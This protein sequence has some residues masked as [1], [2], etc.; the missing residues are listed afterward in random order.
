MLTTFGDII[1]ELRGYGLYEDIFMATCVKYIGITYR[2]GLGLVVDV[3]TDSENPL[4]G[5][6]QQIFVL[7]R[8]AHFIVVL[9]NT[10]YFD[11]HLPVA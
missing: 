8:V 11:R 2:P 3:D 5:K 6:I 9:W 1:S 10:I 4:F 7:K